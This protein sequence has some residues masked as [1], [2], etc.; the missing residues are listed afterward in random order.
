MAVEIDMRKLLA[1]LEHLEPEKKEQSFEEMMRQ[2]SMASALPTLTEINHEKEYLACRQVVQ[3]LT[4]KI[5]VP[6]EFESE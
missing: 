6:D 4:G 2:V 3:H 1:S 5:Y